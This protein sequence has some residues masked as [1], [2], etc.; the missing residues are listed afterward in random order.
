MIWNELPSGRTAVAGRPGLG[1]SIAEGCCRAQINKQL[2]I[3]VKTTMSGR[4][5]RW[6]REK[7]SKTPT[8]L[9]VDDKA[10]LDRPGNGDDLVQAQLKGETPR[11]ARCFARLR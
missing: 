1:G 4:V 5:A 11:L 8:G 9:E 7:R 6:A 2:P 3:G 10:R